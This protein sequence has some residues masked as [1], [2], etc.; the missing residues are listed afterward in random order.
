MRLAKITCIVFLLLVCHASFASGTKVF[1]GS[2]THNTAVHTPRIE[3]RLDRLERRVKE[4]EAELTR[5]RSHSSRQG[6]RIRRY[7]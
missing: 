3:D 7:R 4:L 6:Y 1:V 5:I 2:R